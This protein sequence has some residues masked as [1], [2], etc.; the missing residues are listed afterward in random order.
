LKYL[1]GTELLRDVLPAEHFILLRP[2]PKENQALFDCRHHIANYVALADSIAGTIYGTL[3]GTG[4][5]RN[6][7]LTDGDVIGPTIGITEQMI[8]ES[9]SGEPR[10]GLMTFLHTEIGKQSDLADF[11]VGI[12]D[13]YLDRTFLPSFELKRIGRYNPVTGE[14]RSEENETPPKGRGLS[15]L[16]FDLVVQGALTI[17]DFQRIMEV[18]MT[19]EDLIVSALNAE[20]PGLT[21]PLFE[22]PSG[23]GSYAIKIDGPF[24]ITL[25]AAYR[26]LVDFTYPRRGKDITIGL[27]IPSITLAAGANVRLVEVDASGDVIDEY[28]RIVTRKINAISITNLVARLGMTPVRRDN[29]R[30]DG[31]PTLRFTSG[32]WSKW[33]VTISAADIDVDL[34]DFTELLAAAI[35][36]GLLGHPGFGTILAFLGIGGDNLS[37]EGLEALIRKGLEGEDFLPG[38]IA[39]LGLELPASL[40]R[41]HAAELVPLRFPF[42]GSA[43]GEQISFRDVRV[44]TRRGAQRFFNVREEPD[45]SEPPPTIDP[46]PPDPDDII[47]PMDLGTRVDW[48]GIILQVERGLGGDPSRFIDRRL[49]DDTALDPLEKAIAHMHLGGIPEATIAKLSPGLVNWTERSYLGHALPK[50]AIPHLKA[51]FKRLDTGPDA[52]IARPKLTERSIRKSLVRSQFL[53]QHQINRRLEPVRAPGLTPFTGP[54]EG[55]FECRS[56][57]ESPLGGRRGALGNPAQ[58]ELSCNCVPAGKLLKLMN[59]GGRLAGS[60]SAHVPGLGQA[61]YEVTRIGDIA[62]DF[63]P[64]SSVIG[65]DF[66]GQPSIAVRD[67][68]GWVT[69]PSSSQRLEFSITARIRCWPSYVDAGALPDSAIRHVT[70]NLGTLLEMF[71]GTLTDDI[72]IRELFYRRMVYLVRWDPEDEDQVRPVAPAVGENVQLFGLDAPENEL[73]LASVIGDWLHSRLPLP[74]LFDP[75]NQL[76]GPLSDVSCEQGWIQMRKTYAVEGIAA[77]PS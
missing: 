63:N 76:G 21:I 43:D 8:A 35:G 37:E 1:S 40:T 20:F 62:A 34:S 22:S 67:M 41:A 42:N 11:F 72:R 28:A 24:T 59:A 3:P 33:Q 46:V 9:L 17:G 53:M 27:D 44:E 38:V 55:V 54:L 51:H 6:I 36:A 75:W 52:R 16:L 77:R 15:Q 70:E 30:L 71:D 57:P 14:A 32:D 64:N 12:L 5:T 25:P 69:H 26:A 48:S 60:G 65:R 61:D 58:V 66:T 74:M 4:P 31:W 2:K 39:G 7:T 18:Y 45:A 29:A 56:A 47:D 23:S 10:T 19:V 73:V 68:S 13:E 50:A 49:N